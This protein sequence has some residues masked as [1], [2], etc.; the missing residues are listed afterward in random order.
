V[1]PEDFRSAR[2]RLNLTQQELG[3]KLSEPRARINYAE[4]HARKV[5]DVLIR[6][7]KALLKEEEQTPDG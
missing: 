3:R 4:L 6:K 2:I 7:M 1:S 5:P